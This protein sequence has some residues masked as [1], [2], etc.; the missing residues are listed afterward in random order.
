M[1][2]L[3]LLGNQPYF[4]ILIQ[5]FSHPPLFFKQIFPIITSYD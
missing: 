1:L 3:G 2:G 4:F 5:L